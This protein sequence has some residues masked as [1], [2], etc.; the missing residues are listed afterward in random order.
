M[1][2][3][4]GRTNSVNVQKVVWCLDE[5]GIPHERV[6]AGLQFGKNDEPWYLALNP[7]GRIPLL[8]DGEFSLWESNTIV[9]YLSAKYDFGGLYAEAPETRAL[10]E[11]WM[12][13]QISTL[14][15]P[16]S[17]VFWTLIRTPPAERD[18]GAVT[19][20]TVEANRVTGMLDQALAEQPFVAGE[21]FSM[22]DIP[23]GAVVYRW[24]AIPGIERP[25]LPKLRAWQ[26]RLAERLAGQLSGNMTCR[27]KAGRRPSSGSSGCRCPSP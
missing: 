27:R 26:E 19:R 12:D 11:K 13:W 3:I 6:D 10:A 16:V 1:I 8:Q 18:M 20:A 25:P 7:N 2:K 24:L 5:I 4:W 17:T 23:V 14:L 15:A 22:G 21:R 9:R